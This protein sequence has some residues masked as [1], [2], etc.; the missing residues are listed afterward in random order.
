MY[1]FQALTK[2]SLGNYTD[3]WEQNKVD[4]LLK[5]ETWFYALTS[6]VIIHST[7]I[8]LVPIEFLNTESTPLYKAILLS[9]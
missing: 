4:G 3:I 8:Y 6:F 7:E 5:V 9:S 2:R 1:N